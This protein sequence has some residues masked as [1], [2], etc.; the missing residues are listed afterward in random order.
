[1]N[2]AL[3]VTLLLVAVL[4]LPRTLDMLTRRQPPAPLGLQTPISEF[5]AY[6]AAALDRPWARA[7]FTGAELRA[8]DQLTILYFE[9]DWSLSWLP[10]D[11]AYLATRCRPLEDL[12]PQR[13]SG[14]IMAGP[15][16]TDTELRY[17]RSAAQDPCPAAL[18]QE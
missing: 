6:L 18:K 9:L 12:V 15:P 7:M 1:M 16:S 11:R 14:G 4:L 13:M 3:A 17:L 8:E 2:R 5:G 10:P